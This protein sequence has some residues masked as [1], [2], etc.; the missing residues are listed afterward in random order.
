MTGCG[1]IVSEVPDTT[2]KIAGEITRDLQRQPG[3]ADTLAGIARWWIPMQRM[4][5]A[6]EE[7]Q[8]ALAY[9]EQAGEILRQECGDGTILYL[10]YHKGNVV[11]AA[12]TS[13]TEPEGVRR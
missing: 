4:E 3:A 8:R 13:S 12:S 11:G 2:K 9:L 10:G 6:V 1:A 5:E 7:V